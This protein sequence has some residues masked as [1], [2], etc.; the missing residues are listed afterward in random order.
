MLLAVV[1][2]VGDES[3]MH[4]HRGFCTTVELEV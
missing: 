1:H 2:A 4:R 3:V